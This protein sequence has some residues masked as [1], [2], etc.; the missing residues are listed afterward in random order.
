MTLIAKRTTPSDHPF[1]FAPRWRSQENLLIGI[2]KAIT[3]RGADSDHWGQIEP[4]HTWS[5]CLYRRL[6]RNI[7]DYIR[8]DKFARLMAFSF[9]SRRLS[10]HYIRQMRKGLPPLKGASTFRVRF[11]DLRPLP[12][13][14]RP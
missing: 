12:A 4:G 5:V 3:V 1:V 13:L 2:G 14:A 9:S 11:R 7:V 6:H 10:L 8:R